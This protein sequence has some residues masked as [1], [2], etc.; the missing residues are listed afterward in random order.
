MRPDPN[1]DPTRKPPRSGRASRPIIP[2]P[3]AFQ[4]PSSRAFSPERERESFVFK[5]EEKVGLTVAINATSL[6]SRSSMSSFHGFHLKIQTI[7][8]HHSSFIRVGSEFWV[9][10]KKTQFECFSTFE[11]NTPNFSRYD[12]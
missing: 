8:K 4:I 3:P 7:F 11:P 1:P 12:T 10:E 5:K 6:K 9:F 2:I